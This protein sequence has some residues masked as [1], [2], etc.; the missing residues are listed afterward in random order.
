ML[1]GRLYMEKIAA[2]VKQGKLVGFFHLGL[3]QEAVSAGVLNAVGPNDYIVPTH[4]QQTLLINLLDINRFT[5]ELTGKYNGYCKGLGFEFHTSSKEHRLFPISA[6]LGSSVPMGVGAAMA[7]KLDKSDGVVVC[8]FGEGASSEG[9]VHEAMNIA[10]I[11]KLPVVFLIEDN[12]WAVSQSA[13]RQSAVK[14][15]ATRAAGYGMPGV[16]VDGTDIQQVVEALRKAVADARIYKP[17]IVELKLMRWR[18]HFEGDSQVYRDLSEVEEAKKNDCIQKLEG[19]LIKEH[20]LAKQD[21]DKMR[22]DA[23]QKVE[24]AF[25][26]AEKSPFPPVEEILSINNV[27]AMPSGGLSL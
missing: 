16:T 6:V 2:F 22:Q 1:L 8:C 13:A 7:L 10:S 5:C 4:R 11:S 18:G 27:Y 17:S 21:L 3:G 14:D 20:G 23:A 9:N 15:V 26:F 24:D 25:A 12:G 19:I